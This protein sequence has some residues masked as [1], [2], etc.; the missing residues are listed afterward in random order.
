MEE[1]LCVLRPIPIQ[2][3]KYYLS[4]HKMP[5]AYINNVNNFPNTE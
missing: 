3:T 4:A 5:D 2:I 1:V